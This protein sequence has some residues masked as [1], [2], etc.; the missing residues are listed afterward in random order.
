MGSKL[1]LQG[2][3]LARNSYQRLIIIQILTLWQRRTSHSRPVG[4]ASFIKEIHSTPLKIEE[5]FG[6]CGTAKAPVSMAL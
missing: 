1:A 3:H 4:A 5:F 2:T 6:G